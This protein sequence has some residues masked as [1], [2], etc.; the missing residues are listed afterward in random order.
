MGFIVLYQFICCSLS[1]NPIAIKEFLQDQ[2]I[3]KRFFVL[4]NNIKVLY[5][6]I[7]FY[8]KSYN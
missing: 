6:K 3:E 5:E 4:Y 1:I 2:V 7:N 8:E